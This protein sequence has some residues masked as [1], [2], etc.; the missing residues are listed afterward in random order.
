MGDI[1]AGKENLIG[2]RKMADQLSS[3]N[4]GLDVYVFCDY[5][6]TIK[7]FYIQRWLH[8][9]INYWCVPNPVTTGELWAYSSTV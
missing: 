1:V 7:A 6:F 5:G 3:D 9:I 4:R 2:F 8:S